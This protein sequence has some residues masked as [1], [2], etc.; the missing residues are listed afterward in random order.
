MNWAMESASSSTPQKILGSVPLMG[1]LLAHLDEGTLASADLVAQIGLW[2]DR[3]CTS[4]DDAS[5]AMGDCWADC[6]GGL[7]PPQEQAARKVGRALVDPDARIGDEALG[8]LATAE[9]WWLWMIGMLVRHRRRTG[10]SNDD[11]LMAWRM[12]GWRF[13]FKR[14]SS[15]TTSR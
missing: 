5:N 1:R 6:F 8:F 3:L 12:L 9:G 2:Q 15:P 13:G 14:P 7:L 4:P 10:T 11:P